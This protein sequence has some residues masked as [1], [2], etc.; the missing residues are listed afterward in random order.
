MKQ[1]YM[2]ISRSIFHTKEKWARG[3]PME[4]KKNKNAGAYKLLGILIVL[5][6]IVTILDR[7]GI[8]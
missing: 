8:L 6:F 2:L 7:T 3:K 5:A 4:N 1:G